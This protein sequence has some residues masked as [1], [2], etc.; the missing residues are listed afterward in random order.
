MFLSFLCDL[1][2]ILN[3]SCIDNSSMLKSELKNIVITIVV[4]TSITGLVFRN[5]AEFPSSCALRREMTH[6]AMT[7]EERQVLAITDTLVRIS[8]GL[9]D[10]RDLIRD[11]E[12]ALVHA[13][14]AM[15][16]NVIFAYIAVAYNSS[17]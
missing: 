15:T 14:R 9:E 4:I 7:E 13:V 1:G 12:Q 2:M 8:V 6:S 16:D 5:L 11:L 17:F 3:A 10:P